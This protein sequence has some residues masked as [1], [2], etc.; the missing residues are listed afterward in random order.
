[1]GLDGHIALGIADA[2]Q[3]PSSLLLVLI[4]KGTL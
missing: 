3:D 2:G 1:M 4:Q